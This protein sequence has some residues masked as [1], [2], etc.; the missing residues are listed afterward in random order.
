L[1]VVTAA[2]IPW[3]LP[4]T[5]STADDVIEAALLLL[6]TID[7]PDVVDLVEALALAVVTEREANQARRVL[8]GETIEQW[9][10]EGTERRRLTR[11]LHTLLD[12]R[13]EAARV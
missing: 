12:E 9:H 4:L 2:D 13:R 11:R 8:L 1:I 6:P 5:G 10:R 3:G 7:D